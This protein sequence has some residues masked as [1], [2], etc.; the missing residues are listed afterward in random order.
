MNFKKEDIKMKTA[1]IVAYDNNKLIGNNGKL[2][3]PKINGDMKHFYNV[4]KNNIVV[5]GRKTFE[6]IGCK[7]L[8]NRTNIIITNIFKT[9]PGCFVAS[10]VQNAYKIALE[11]YC[12]KTIFFIGGK[13]VFEEALNLGVN[14]IYI[15]RVESEYERNIYFPNFSLKKYKEIEWIERNNYSIHHFSDLNE[16]Q[17]Q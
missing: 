8:S 13:R 9:F 17:A 5:M 1:I 16:Y 14:D 3:W 2:P 15:T 12:K 11:N 10:S 7:P 4:T 6:S